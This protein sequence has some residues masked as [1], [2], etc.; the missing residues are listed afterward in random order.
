MS[1][2]VSQWLIVIVFS[3][4]NQNFLAS[5]TCVFDQPPK[6]YL[7]MYI[8]QVHT[9]QAIMKESE[10]ARLAL[11]ARANEALQ[12]LEA[13]EANSQALRQQN[14]RWVLYLCGLKTILH[15]FTNTLFVRVL[16]SRRKRRHSDFVVIL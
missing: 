16:V 9:F 3:I 15:V 2:C 5:C 1:V 4:Q 7:F 6:H 12:L 13:A 11:E 8:F 14:T 10:E